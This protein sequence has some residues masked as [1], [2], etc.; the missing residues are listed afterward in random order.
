MEFCLFVIEYLDSW[1]LQT[2]RKTRQQQN[3]SLFQTWVKNKEI[4]PQN[5]W[6]DNDQDIIN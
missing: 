1:V 4:K 6:T 5:T 2:K 3:I